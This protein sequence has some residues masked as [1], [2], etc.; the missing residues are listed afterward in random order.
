MQDETTGWLYPLP[1]RSC[2]PQLAFV[3]KRHSTD[4][5]WA[6]AEWPG[7][8]RVNSAHA[9]QA[10]SPVSEQG[11]GG[12]L[13]QQPR[14]MGQGCRGWSCWPAPV[15]WHHTST[16]VLRLLPPQRSSPRCLPYLPL[17]SH[18]PSLTLDP[19][20]VAPIAMAESV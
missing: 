9:D 20:L 6:L 18:L 7:S 17:S 4:E 10:G 5:V 1:P 19:T 2:A 3:E 8:G 12:C 14:A 15:V 16:S 13:C 11:V